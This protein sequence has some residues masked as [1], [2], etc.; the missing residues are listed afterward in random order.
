M[1]KGNH[2][3]L[4]ELLVVIAIIAILAAMLLPALNK[5]RE[6]ARQSHCLNN[7]K[8]IGLGT[9]MYVDTYEYYMPYL[10]SGA[11][12]WNGKTWK[13]GYPNWAV[14]LRELDFLKSPEN[15]QYATKGAFACPE[16][17][18]KKSCRSGEP[19]VA[20]GFSNGYYS[21]Y[22]YNRW[23]LGYNV[24]DKYKGVSNQKSSRILYPS[25]TVNVCD[26]DYSA[27]GDVDRRKYIFYRHND[28][29]NTLFADGH[30]EKIKNLFITFNG[31]EPYW[32]SGLKP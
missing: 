7:T 4:I 18:S 8:Q 25:G 12:T 22:T 32:C 17:E 30:S 1:K 19:G 16:Y 15:D 23:R 31:N 11:S 20:P 28:T 9:A 5:A 29:A 21:S 6:A 24:D 13:S 10:M 27:L 2:F 26:G 3:T 14:L